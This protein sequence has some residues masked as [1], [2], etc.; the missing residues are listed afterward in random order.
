MDDYW[1]TL[2]FVGPI[3]LLVNGDK[4]SNGSQH[5]LLVEDGSQ[6]SSE[7]GVVGTGH[8]AAG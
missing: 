8:C 5:C 3:V 4:P 2:I 1:I 6:A 7:Q